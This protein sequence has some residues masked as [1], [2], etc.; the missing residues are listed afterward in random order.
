MPK[1]EGA[2]ETNNVGSSCTDEQACLKTRKQVRVSKCDRKKI[3]AKADRDLACCISTIDR[4]WVA[5]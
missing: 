3:S 2:E 5:Q 4:A 1:W